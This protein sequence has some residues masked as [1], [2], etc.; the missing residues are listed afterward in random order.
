MTKDAL[1]AKMETL[2]NFIQNADAQIQ[3]GKMVK[4]GT[5]DR[6]VADLCDKVVRLPAAE[7]L[8][9]Q[10]AMADLIGELERLSFSL[11]DF[12]DNLKN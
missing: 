8:E 11:K 6:D 12:R 3:S 10:P 4:L 7:A 1:H 2:K 5:L 9:M